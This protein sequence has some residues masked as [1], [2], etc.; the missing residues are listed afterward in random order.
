MAKANYL[1]QIRKRMDDLQKEFS[2]LTEAY[3][4]LS[5]ASGTRGR[6]AILPSLS[7]LVDSTA[8]KPGKKAGRPAKPG[9]PGRPAGSK[10]KPGSKKPGP[11]PK[12]DDAP[13]K[14]VKSG[15]KPGRPAG[16]VAAK[17]VAKPAGK[18]GRP[19][20]KSSGA[21][22]GKRSRIGNISGKIIDIVAKGNRFTT[23]SVITDKL[24]PLYPG[25]DRADLGKYISVILA[26]MKARK[27]LIVITVDAKGN[28]MRSGL[29]GLPTWFDGGKP[30]NEFLK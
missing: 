10:S 24:V 19:A 13:S 9:R 22:K 8:V 21:S 17:A 29:W 5:S 16:K 18:R 14:P 12:T 28:K 2:A 4:L 3:S 15:R 25:K 26:N 1:G 7:D 11:K 27:E 6:K 20:G 30:K 23:N